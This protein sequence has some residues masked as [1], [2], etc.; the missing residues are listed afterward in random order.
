MAGFSGALSAFALASVTI[1]A[2]LLGL[3]VSLA[4]AQDAVTRFLDSGPVLVKR[5]TGIALIAVGVWLIALALWAG[6]FA[7]VFPV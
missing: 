5:W 3:S 4:L 6:F 1:T 7:R 2:L